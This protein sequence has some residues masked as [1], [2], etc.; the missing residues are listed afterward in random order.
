MNRPETVLQGAK[1]TLP[2]TTLDHIIY[3]AHRL[4]TFEA[5]P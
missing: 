2:R 5:R 3:K 4:P 1:S